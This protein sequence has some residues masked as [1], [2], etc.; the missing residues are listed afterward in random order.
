MRGAGRPAALAAL[1][2]LG[3]TWDPMV[4]SS[5]SHRVVPR[6]LA[7]ELQHD[8]ASAAIMT[9]V[10][11]MSVTSRRVVDREQLVLHVDHPRSAQRLVSHSR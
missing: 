8:R 11:A 10:G 7:G 9:G 5:A 2:M 4:R 1:V 6:P 3:T